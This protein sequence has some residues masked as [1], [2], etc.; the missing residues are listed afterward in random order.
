MSLISATEHANRMIEIAK[1]AVIQKILAL[2]Q[3][4]EVVDLTDKCFVL[5]SSNVSTILKSN[6]APTFY[7]FKTSYRAVADLVEGAALLNV[8]GVL[9]TVLD[10]GYVGKQKLHPEAVSNLKSALAEEIGYG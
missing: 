4:S 8:V 2:P 9:R 10:T 5:K 6:M 7:N 3:N 1:D